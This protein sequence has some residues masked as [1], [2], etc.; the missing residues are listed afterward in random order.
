MFQAILL[1]ILHPGSAHNPHV[2]GVR[3][4]Y[5]ALAVSKLSATITPGL[6]VPHSGC[7]STVR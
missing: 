4:G 7:N 3:S 1:A 6:L 2:P 5:C